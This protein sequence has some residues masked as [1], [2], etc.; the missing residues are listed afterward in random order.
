MAEGLDKVVSGKLRRRAAILMTGAALGGFYIWMQPAVLGTLEANSAQAADG[1]SGCVLKVGS[2]PLTVGG[3]QV[4]VQSNELCGNTSVNLAA[5]PKQIIEAAEPPANLL[6]ATIREEVRPPS[7]VERFAGA[8]PRAKPERVAL[9]SLGPE[10]QIRETQSHRDDLEREHLRADAAPEPVDHPSDDKPDNEH[11]DGGEH[12]GVSSEGGE[13]GGNDYDRDCNDREV[14]S[15]DD[16]GRD[17]G[18]RDG[19]DR[20]GGEGGEGGGGGH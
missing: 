12:G 18:D 10:P 7:P 19:G 1:T 15:R 3:R 17:W 14:A 13:H 9:A 8:A 2:T 5:P 4:R 6:R 11:E 16:N 20:D